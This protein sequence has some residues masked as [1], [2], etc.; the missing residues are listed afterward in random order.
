MPRS[1]DRA[2]AFRPSLESLEHREV[3]AVDFSLSGGVLSIDGGIGYDQIAINDYGNGTLRVYNSGSIHTF[4]GVT[5][6]DVTMNRGDDV[7]NYILQGNRTT[8]I[9][10]TIDLGNGDDAFTATIENKS[11][12]ADLLMHVYGDAGKDEMYADVEADVLGQSTLRTF[13]YGEGDEDFIQVLATDVDVFGQFNVFA[14][15]GMNN[16]TIKVITRGEVDLLMSV[17]VFGG[18][19]G[20]TIDVDVTLDPGSSGTLFNTAVDGGSGGDDMSF[21]VRKTAGDPVTVGATVAGGIGNDHAVISA[22]LIQYGT[23]I[24]NLLLV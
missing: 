1:S 16:D 17:R 18:E 11:I 23:D 2:P 10:Y 21:F 20:D 22:T 3:P 7:V 9:D 8:D 24:E 6:V 14:G 4:G 19:Y 5:E 15:G 13:F 12:G